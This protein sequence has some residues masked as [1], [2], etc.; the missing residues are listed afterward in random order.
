MT[1]DDFEDAIDRLC[2][3]LGPDQLPGGADPQRGA[4]PAGGTAGARRRLPH[5]PRS[6]RWRHVQHAAA[7]RPRWSVA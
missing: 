1:S 2:D 3:R 5:R 7:A 6:T 4:V